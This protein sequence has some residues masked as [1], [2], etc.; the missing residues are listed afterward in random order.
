MKFYAMNSFDFA[1]GYTG[2]LTS[3][4][5]LKA[6]LRTDQRI[7]FMDEII[8]GVQVIKMYAWEK[9]FGHLVLMARK[10]ELNQIR[11]ISYIRGI[12]MTFMLFPARLALFCAMLATAIIFGPQQITAD[13]IF[14]LSSYYSMLA[15]LMNQQF[16]RGWAEVCEVSVS[17]KRLQSFL[18]L[19]EK[20]VEPIAYK[21][22][23]VI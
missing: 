10:L 2:K 4:Y 13:R 19:D 12:H 6:A 9:P 14:T 20:D 5:R 17:L 1:K 7:R 15:M 11:K 8:S 16:I 22:T 21:K 3:K 18:E 23:E